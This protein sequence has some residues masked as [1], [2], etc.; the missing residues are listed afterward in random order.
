MVKAIE[1][2]LEGSLEISLVPHKL[3]SR[4]LNMNHLSHVHASMFNIDHILASI[5]ESRAAFIASQGVCRV[6]AADWP[7]AIL[8]VGVSPSISQ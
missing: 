2:S 1:G 3:A 6:T 7:K 5:R 4:R 8:S